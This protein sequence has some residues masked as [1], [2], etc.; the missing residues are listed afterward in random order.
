MTINTLYF[1]IYGDN[2]VECSR[3]FEYI[4]KG[5]YLANITL[6]K[7]YNIENISAPRFCILTDTSQYIFTFIPGTSA[8]RWDK[9]IY[10][11]FVLNN[12]GP[13]KEG[14]DAIITRVY[15]KDD[16]EILTSM[17]FSAALPAGNNTWQRSGRA[18]SLSAAGIPYF[19]IVHLGGKE[20]KK[21]KERSLDK[22]ST[23]LPNPALSLSFTLNTINM[24]APSLIVYD[25]APE[26]DSTIQN[27]YSDCYGIEDFSLYLYK[28]ITEQNYDK[29]LQNIYKKNILFLKL[30]SHDENGKNFTS[31]DYTYVFQH[32]NP[33]SGLAQV[34]KERKIPWKKK[35]AAK[36]FENFS[37]KHRTPIFRLIEFLS[38]YSYGIASKD[39]LPLTFVPAE[40]RQEVAD[41]ICQELY[42]NKISKDFISWIYKEEDLVICTINGFKPRGDDSR[43]DRGLPPFAKMLANTDILTLIFGPALPI[44]WQQLDSKPEHLNKTNGLW[45]SIFAFSDAILVESS[46]RDNEHFKYNTYLKEHWFTSK[47]KK[48]N[49]TPISY[50]PKIVGEHDV[51]T[52]LHILFAYIG[53]HFESVCNPPGGDWSGVSLLKNNLEYRWT[54]MNRVSEEGTKRPDHIYQLLYNSIDTLLL[55]ES[56][57]IKNDLMKSQEANVGIG[58]INYLKNLMNRDY[59]AIRDANGWK[60]IHG[61]MTIDDFQVFS[62]VAYLFT[63]DFNVEYSSSPTLF[64]HSNSQLIFALEIKKTVSVM[65]IFTANMAAYK[66]AEFLFETMD[67]S[68]LPLKIYKPI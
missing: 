17:E 38:D 49:T 24:A 28:L 47:K 45:Q 51:D 48:K 15:G 67:N 61:Q 41:F 31:N 65:H 23:R 43:P 46:T 66:F 26:A 6:T 4:L 32:E 39:S 58:M 20:F 63:N 35:M 9:D 62:A 34:I 30:R 10:T 59:T 50:F 11:E 14:A 19:Y 64:Q 60:N 16:E 12:G 53:N 18:Y 21:G 37:L 27:Y 44:Q 42:P 55:I 25:N 2:I 3:A 1:N 5:F 22:F 29:E 36:T 54:S 13:L 40:N 56:K 68:H 57:G 52:S 7:Q 33:Y 8:A